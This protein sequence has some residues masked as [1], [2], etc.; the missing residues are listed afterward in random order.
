MLY[1]LSI[2]IFEYIY[3]DFFNMFW[4]PHNWIFT[5]NK[6]PKQI[7]SNAPSCPPF[8]SQHFVPIFVP[9][10]VAISPLLQTVMLASFRKGRKKAKLTTGEKWNSFKDVGPPR[11]VL[12]WSGGKDSFLALK[13]LQNDI[14][15]EKQ[16][17]V[18]GR[19][20]RVTLLTTFDGASGKI[21]F[22]DT[23]A[24]NTF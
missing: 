13:A 2:S 8:I 15:R 21:A 12:F 3:M 24:R 19:R 20:A 22:Q 16:G 9:N 17:Q 11:Q 23:Q 4:M 7:T 18:P 6:N 5:V 10:V 1:F 14:R